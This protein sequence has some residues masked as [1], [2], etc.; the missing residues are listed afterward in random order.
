MSTPE[1]IVPR[2]VDFHQ[3]QIES[4]ME[5]DPRELHLK[6]TIWEEEWG[7]SDE[8]GPLRKVLMRTPSQSLVKIAEEAYHEEMDAL[9][10]PEGG[11][12]WMGTKAPDLDVVAAQHG[13]L[14]KTLRDEGVEVELLP[15]NDRIWAKSMY[16]RDPLITV[17]GGA[18]VGRL[19]P[20]MRRGEEA[21]ITQEIASLGVPI[22]GTVTGDGTLEG[23]SFAKLRPGVAAFGTSIRCNLA[24]AEQLRW[25]L[26]NIGWELIVVPLPGYVVHLDVH[27]AMVDVDRALINP[28]GLPYDFLKTLRELGIDCI[29]AHPDEPWAMNVLTV[30]PGRIITSTSAPRTAEILTSEGIDVLTIP[31]DELHKNGGGIHCSTMELLRDSATG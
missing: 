9:V 5:P 25:M 30:S 24:G 14:I 17:P 23:G 1:A 21:F 8:V 7:S 4:A 13:G 22:L 11:W 28:S 26:A 6:R 2:P 29:V 15:P 10:D 16:T 19:T 12:Y 3:T 18:I 27:F 31:Y 20:K